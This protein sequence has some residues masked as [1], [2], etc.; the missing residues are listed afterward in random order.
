MTLIINFGK[1]DEEQGCH[2]LKEYR[3]KAE[4]ERAAKLDPES[5]PGDEIDSNQPF[6]Q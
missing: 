6:S 4:A 2:W 5:K 3:E 1:A